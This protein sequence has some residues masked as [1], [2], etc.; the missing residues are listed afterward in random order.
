MRMHMRRFK[1]KTGNHIRMVA[2]CT[3]WYN[4]VKMHKT[5]W[6]SPATAAGLTDRL[7]SMA[8]VAK[9]VEGGAAKPGKRGPYRKRSMNDY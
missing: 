4:L 3:A 5:L 9:L 8:N 6:M 2:I 1:R 7:W